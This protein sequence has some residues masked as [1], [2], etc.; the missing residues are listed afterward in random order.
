[1]HFRSCGGETN[2]L[3]GTR[4][5]HWKIFPV[6]PVGTAYRFSG[7]TALLLQL[8]SALQEMLIRTEL[9]NLL[10]SISAGC[11]REPHRSY[12]RH[13]AIRI[14]IVVR[15]FLSIKERR[16][17][18]FFLVSRR[19]IVLIFAIQGPKFFVRFWVED[20]HLVFL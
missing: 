6:F 13:F 16:R 5:E 8:L 7:P 14:A 19:Q 4:L 10:C 1:M 11:R 9:Q 15:A 18:G 17:T 20:P 2:L 12:K 3:R